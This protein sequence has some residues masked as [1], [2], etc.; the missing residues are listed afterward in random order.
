MCYHLNTEIGKVH[1]IFVKG[2]FIDCLVKF[3]S[4][5]IGI[6]SICC[7][8]E[9]PMGVHDLFD[10]LIVFLKNSKQNP[11]PLGITHS[12]YFTLLTVI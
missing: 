3:G 5:V 12:F 2:L 4:T 7:T 10:Y 11:S 9:M 1:R 8:L 6:K